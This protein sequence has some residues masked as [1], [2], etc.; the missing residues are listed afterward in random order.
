[1]VQKVSFLKK[2]F[3]L[4][5][6]ANFGGFII[7]GLTSMVAPQL[8]FVRNVIISSFVI[9]LPIST[10]QWLA[11]RRLAPVSWLWIL[12]LPLGLLASVLVMRYSPNIWLPFV[13]DDESPLVIATGYLI[14]GI[15][16]GLPQRFLLRPIFPKASLWI[17]ATAGGLAVGMLLVLITNLIN[18]SGFLSIIVVVLFYTSA[19]GLTL[20]RWLSQSSSLSRFSLKTIEPS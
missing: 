16:I 10:A 1:M 9:T 19:T 11:L 3:L 7:L 8:V 14:G 6:M 15:L 5:M 12:S 2:P 17:L 18:L 20:S 4:W 13:V